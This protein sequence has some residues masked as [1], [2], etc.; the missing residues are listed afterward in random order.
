MVNPPILSLPD[1]SKSFIVETDASGSG[2]EAVL[3]QE[4]HPITYINKALGL[5]QQVLSTCKRE[6]LAILLAITKWKQYLWGR[7]FKIRTDHVSLKYL[8][9]QKISSPSQ[10]LWLTKL[11]RFDYKIEFC[12]GRENVAANAFSGITNNELNA[13]ALSRISTPLIADIKKSW[14]EDNKIQ[15]IIQDLM[16]DLA[17]YP[18]YKWSDSYLFRKGKLVVENNPTSAY[19]CLSWYITHLGSTVT[20]A[21]VASIFYLKK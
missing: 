12:K 9:D 7:S 15:S 2:I 5:R 8:L 14:E 19:N 4:G 20:A 11:L 6:M 10:H 13:L 17:T 16:K 3:M 18:H 21:R 1:M